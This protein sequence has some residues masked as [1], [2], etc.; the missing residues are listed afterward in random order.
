VKAD[1]EVALTFRNDG[2]MSHNLHIP[3]LGVKT[4]TIGPGKT[5]T[6]RF[7]PDETGTVQFVCK[8]PGHEQA[9]MKGEITVQ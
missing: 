3:E 9:G 7:T 6:V 1:R 5:A 4:D 8:V 2:K